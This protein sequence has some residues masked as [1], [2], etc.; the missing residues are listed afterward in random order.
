MV[1]WI[2]GCSLAK[3]DIALGPDGATTADTLVVDVA[4]QDDEFGDPVDFEFT[5]WRDGELRENLVTAEV[6]PGETARDQV[7]EVQVVAV[8]GSET[9]RPA[10]AEITIENAPPT[11]VLTL[12]E[13]TAP[14]ADL[15]AFASTTDPDGDDVD[16]SWAWQVDGVDAGID[17]DTVPASETQS[18]QIWTAICTASDGDA[19][20][21]DEIKGQI[22]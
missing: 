14:D 6:L 20:T 7:W 15:M 9:S 10:L 16:V 5:W 3:P 19:E 17:S 12:A 22:D 13:R 21:V 2:L 11:L 8:A 18:G 4:P 1:L